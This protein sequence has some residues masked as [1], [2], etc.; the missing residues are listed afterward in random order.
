MYCDINEYAKC[1]DRV[2]KWID[3]SRRA[4]ARLALRDRGDFVRAGSD[5]GTVVLA[6]GDVFSIRTRT[7]PGVAGDTTAF[8]EFSE[9]TPEL[10][11]A[12]SPQVVISSVLGRNFDCVDLAERLCEVG[13]N[14]CYR[15][16][17]HGMPQPDLV[18][19]EIRSLFPSLR[20]ELDATVN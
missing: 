3:I 14:G 7:A 16:I 8:A 19:R 11:E 6:V 20:V 18:L 15:L 12:L 9:V 13:F 5:T 17:A 4:V 1:K 2:E 10:M